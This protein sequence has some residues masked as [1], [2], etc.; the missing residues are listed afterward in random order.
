[1]QAQ[2]RR[3]SPDLPEQAPPAGPLVAG[4][5]LAVVRQGRRI[6]DGVDLAVGPGEIVTLIGPNGAGKSTLV[7]VLIGLERPDEGAVTARP[8]LRIGYSPQ[9]MALDPALPLDVRRFLTLGT[10]AGRERLVGVLARVG[11][12]EPLLG[13][14]MRALSGG[15]LHR[16]LLARALLRKPDL[17]VLDEPLSGVDVS[18]Q[19]ELY[20]LIDRIREETGAGVLLVSHDLHLVMART[21]RVL[22]LDG[23]VC[24]AGRPLEVARD[25]AFVRL[26]GPRYGD[27]LA[28]YRPRADPHHP[29]GGPG[30]HGHH[31]APLEVVGDGGERP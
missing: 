11:L 8:G 5:G 28:F 7:R 27:V 15:E 6:L 17:L 21:D 23:H 26:F 3:T 14:Q 29:P 24:C 18:G 12:A 9:L 1:M 2:I 13:R 4:R 22:C 25:P 16:V 19:L 30:V 10:P 20:A 31:H